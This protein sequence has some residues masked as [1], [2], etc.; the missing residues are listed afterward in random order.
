MLE[1]TPLTCGGLGLRIGTGLGLTA[2][3]AGLEPTA[4]GPGLAPDGGWWCG[5]LGLVR[6]LLLLLLLWLLWW[7]LYMSLVLMV[8]SNSPSKSYAEG[9]E[10]GIPWP[11]PPPPPRDSAPPFLSACI[12]GCSGS[13]D[14][15]D[16]KCVSGVYA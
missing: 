12:I 15:D 1:R 4:R 8:T 2:E 13:D 10:G 5:L 7:L 6:I 14:G 11:P 16:I 3:G 9:R